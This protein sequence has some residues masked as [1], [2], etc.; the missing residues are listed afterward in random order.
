MSFSMTGGF[1]AGVFYPP[2]S[3]LYEPSGDHP[4]IYSDCFAPAGQSENYRGFLFLTTEMREDYYLY[5]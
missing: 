4:L 3:P 5:S 1:Y 2:C